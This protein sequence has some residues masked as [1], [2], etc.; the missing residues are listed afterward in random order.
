MHVKGLVRGMKVVVG[1][2]SGQC[3]N[4]EPKMG[5]KGHFGC[6]MKPKDFSKVSRVKPHLKQQGF[7]IYVCL[8]IISIYTFMIYVQ[9]L[10]TLSIFL[11]KM[12]FQ[13]QFLILYGHTQLDTLHI[14]GSPPTPSYFDQPLA[15]GEKP[16]ESM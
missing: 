11:L 7:N 1:G 13:I 14:M 2:G 4:L 12:H 8:Y 15:M 3:L 5:F 9:I 10:L 6:Q 16:E